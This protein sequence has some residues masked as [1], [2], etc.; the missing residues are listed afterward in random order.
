MTA[1]HAYFNL[2]TQQAF[3]R[4]LDAPTRTPSSAPLGLSSSGGKSWGRPSPLSSAASAAIDVNA[5]DWL[6]RTALHLAASATDPSA[7]EYVRMLL[8]HPNINV[9]VA[10][11]E[12]HWTALHRA[13][14]H[15]NIASAVQLLQRSDID[16]SLKDLEGY[17]AF[18]LYNSTVE[19]TKPSL[20]DKQL[21]ADIFT[22][23]A[24]R[25]ATL[26]VGDG[27]DRAFPEAILLE[28]AQAYGDSARVEERFAPI[29]VQQLAMSKLHTG[30]VTDERRANLR[31]CGFG[32]GGRCVSTTI[33]VVTSAHLS[34]FRR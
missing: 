30:V 12:S 25:N 6:G 11:T 17:T 2:R 15:G 3:Q 10:D 21:I 23:G 8:A 32:S 14:Y 29:H 16:V 27:D 34:A 24:N 5:R 28:S 33:A 20:A 7:P 31:A 22:W 26:G 4:L 18:D 19:G 13:L 1:L 9:N